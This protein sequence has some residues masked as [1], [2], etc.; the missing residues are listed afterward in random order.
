MLNTT[1]TVQT[2]VLMRRVPHLFQDKGRREHRFHL[3]R[4]PLTTMMDDVHQASSE[5]HSSPDTPQ[6][7][8][9]PSK[10][11][12][13]VEGEPQFLVEGGSQHPEHRPHV[14]YLPSPNSH[15]ASRPQSSNPIL[16]SGPPVFSIPHPMQDENRLELQS[17]SVESQPSSV[18]SSPTSSRRRNVPPLPRG[19]Y[20]NSPTQYTQ[21]RS[22]TSDGF[23]TASEKQIG[24]HF[25]LRMCPLI[26]KTSSHTDCLSFQRRPTTTY[27]LN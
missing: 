13:R 15:I 20:F 4:S 23:T 27:S 19:F 14:F 12:S 8:L 16:V 1:T 17:S 2:F 18:E 21:Y 6:S 24:N 11:E 25:G 10:G 7:P 5:S 9:P 26:L 22:E 3:P